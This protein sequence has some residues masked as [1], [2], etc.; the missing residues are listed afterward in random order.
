MVVG[1]ILTEIIIK[2]SV[3]GTH[4]QTA[5]TVIPTSDHFACCSWAASPGA[6]TA[7]S[8]DNRGQV[9]ARK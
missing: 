7:I 4:R 1:I 8:S 5:R 2:L 9:L 6:D 3:A